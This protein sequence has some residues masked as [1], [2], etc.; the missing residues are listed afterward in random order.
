MNS[1]NFLD[2]ITIIPGLCSGEPTI[3]GMRFR[4][5]NILEAMAE[6]ATRHDLL[7]SFPDLEDEDISAALAFAAK[8]TMKSAA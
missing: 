2:R 8:L 6:G 1:E 4:V 3:R 7:D 5:S